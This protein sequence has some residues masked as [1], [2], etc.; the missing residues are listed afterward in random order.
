MYVCMYVCMH[1]CM[2]A[3]NHPPRFHQT[4]LYGIHVRDQS[5][6]VYLCMYVCMYVFMY[7]RMYVWRID[8]RH[9][10]LHET[11]T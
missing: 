1:V 3:H 2:Y 4:L 10:N 11:V 9:Y 5:V 6:R 7:V 8:Y